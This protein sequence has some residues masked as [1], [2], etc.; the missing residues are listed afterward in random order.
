[1]ISQNHCRRK[2]RS[3]RPV[4]GISSCVETSDQVAPTTTLGTMRNP[5]R[6]RRRF[7]YRQLTMQLHWRLEFAD[8]ST[9]G[10]KILSFMPR[11]RPADQDEKTYESNRVHIRS[12][13]YVCASYTPLAHSFYDVSVPRTPA[14]ESQTAL[15]S[16]ESCKQLVIYGT[17]FSPHHAYTNL[18]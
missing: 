6:A 2:G 12:I 17:Y 16:E 3:I 5:F 4:P 15:K 8:I 10:R 1:M 9:S 18:T 14:V 7:P 11:S 13:V